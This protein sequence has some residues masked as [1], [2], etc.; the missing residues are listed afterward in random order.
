M[1]KTEKKAPVN[2]S[3]VMADVGTFLKNFF[4]K[5]WGA[6]KTTVKRMGYAF[7]ILFHPFD[8]FFDLKNDPKRRSVS[9]GVVYLIIF[10]VVSLLRFQSLGYLFA[11][12]SAQ[13]ELNIPV[14]LMTSVLPFVLW[15]VANWCFSSLMDGDGKLSDIFMVTAFSTLPITICYLIQ[16]PLSHFLSGTEA[17][18]FTFIGALGMVW[19]YSYVFLSM[20]VVH[21]Y[22]VAKGLGTAVLTILGM[23]VIAFVAILVFFLLQQISSFFIEIGTEVIFR[24]NE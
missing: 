17:G 23:A 12:R 9:A 4:G 10:A 18:I 13:M 16:I 7:Y 21:Q 19:G 1:E 2:G 14:Y 11:D 15:S 8:G 24:L 20:I 5:C 22:S 6:I 3:K